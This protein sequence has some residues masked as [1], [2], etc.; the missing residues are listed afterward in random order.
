MILHNCAARWLHLPA[1]LETGLSTFHFG[2]PMD[3]P[4]AL[5]RVPPEVVLC[6]NLD[7]A[8]V[9][10][11]AAPTEVRARAVELLSKTA[12]HRNCVLSSGCDLPASAPLANLDALYAVVAEG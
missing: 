5:G 11:Q 1:I 7:P 12:A 4:A 9:F 10:C 6:G 3:L 2:A 8:S